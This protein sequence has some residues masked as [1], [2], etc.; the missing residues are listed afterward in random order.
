MKN[1]LTRCVGMEGSVCPDLFFGDTVAGAVYLLCSDGFRHRI[2][3]TEI[4]GALGGEEGAA[5][6]RERL[7]NLV[8]LNRQRGEKDNISAVAI[9][10]RPG[11]AQ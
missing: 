11:A 9:V 3:E 5:D 2:S 1:V 6:M 10:C 8:A 4:A 7:D